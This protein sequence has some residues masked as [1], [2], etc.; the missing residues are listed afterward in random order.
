MNGV[1]NRDSDTNG[2]RKSVMTRSNWDF[3]AVRRSK[4]SPAHFARVT[5]AP[6]PANTLSSAH[7]I[8]V[9]SSMIRMDLLCSLFI[10][11][12]FH[13]NNCARMINT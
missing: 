9:L 13:G 5:T 2:I 4:A 3:V 6:L 7:S 11:F 1:N 10:S 8:R 12:G